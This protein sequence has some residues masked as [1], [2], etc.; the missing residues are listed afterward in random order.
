MAP[1]DLLELSRIAILSLAR[2]PVRSALTILGLTIGTCTLIDMMAFGEGA[3]RAVLEQF[4]G[5]GTN[6]VRVLPQTEAGSSEFTAPRPLDENDRV[7]LEREIADAVRVVPSVRVRVTLS[8]TTGAAA[9]SWIHATTPDNFPLHHRDMAL[10][11]AFD[12]TDL[13]N[14]AKVCVLGKT[15]ALVLFG[16]DDVI[17]RLVTLD[18]RLTCN[19]VG[20]LAEK[21]LSTSGKDQD[22]LIMMPLSTYESYIGLTSGYSEIEIETRSEN[23]VDAVRRDAAVILRRTH[24][25]ADDLPDD[26]RV[27]SPIDAVEA[28]RA[29]SDTIGAL[30][31]VLALVSLFVGGIGI[32]NIQLVSVAER[33]AEIGMRS[34]IGASPTQILVQFLVESIV[35]SSIGVGL[36]V[37]IGVTLA[38]V[39]A[40][41]LHWHESVTFA[42]VALGAAFGMSVGVAFG[43]LPAKRAAE[44]DPIDALRRE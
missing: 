12:A 22:E 31:A 6:I 20:V 35:L 32:M 26:V 15:T 5:L 41:F 4:S 38:L 30:L 1:A 34:S 19:I 28:A 37:T 7:S 24:A 36:G 13:A 3:K 16:T 21:G 14:R 43:Y 33:T 44:L 9:Q 17:G 29:A 10:G 25:I 2:R 18:E 39:G 8:T 42:Q 23:D 40:H 11:G 27:T